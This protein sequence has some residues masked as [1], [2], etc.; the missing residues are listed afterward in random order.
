MDWRIKAAV[1]KILSVAPAG[2]QINFLLARSLGTYRRMISVP[3]VLRSGL[4]IVRL[5]REHGL[6]MEGSVVVEIG[7]GW[8][9]TIPLLFSCIG[10]SEV[11][12]YDIARHIT[13]YLAMRTFR[14]LLGMLDEVSDETGVPRRRLEIWRRGLRTAGD[15]EELLSSAGIRYV[16]PGNGKRTSLL[17]ATVDLVF[18]RGL[19]EHVPPSVACAL[20]REAHR[21]LK[22]SALMF[23]TIGLHDHYTC[24]DK[25]I[26]MV[27]FLKYSRT[28]WRLLGQTKFCYQNRLRRSQ[29]KEM[30]FRAGFRILWSE[31][32]V[33]E[34]S[35]K[36]LHHMKVAE[37]FQALPPEDLA[38]YHLK[39]LARQ[40]NGSQLE[41]EPKDQQGGEE[42]P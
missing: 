1:Q 40:V 22:P 4:R 31:A 3:T 16:A 8:E 24:V 42:K 7:T 19:L 12:T 27:N 9:P 6:R 10:A 28:A 36:A 11:V 29:L 37:P 15:V 20:L 39:V 38:T 32:K 33:D 41:E 34:T 30:I 14:A 2:R 13:P 17:P 18:T 23:H 21:V 5:C 26:T 25:S 35:L